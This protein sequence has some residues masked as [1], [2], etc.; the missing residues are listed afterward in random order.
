MIICIDILI[1]VCGPYHTTFIIASGGE[2][3]VVIITELNI[4]DMTGVSPIRLVELL[5]DN[6]R[7]LE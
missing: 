1:E 5:G 6:N 2:K 4:G 3:E 7:I